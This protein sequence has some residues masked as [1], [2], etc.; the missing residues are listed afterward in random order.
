ME[1]NE[2]VIRSLKVFNLK[3]N[4]SISDMRAAYLGRTSHKKFQKIFFGDEQ[5]EKEFLKY[6]EAYMIY[7][8]NYDEDNVDLST[9]P[10]DKGFKFI[11]NQ[12]LYHMIRQQYMKAFEKF[13]EA[14]KLNSED[15][16]LLLYL[17][18]ILM[19]RKNY[20]AA[21]KYLLKAAE[22]DKNNDDSWF[23][24]G[25]IYLKTGNLNKAL[26]MFETC[27]ILNPLRS[28]VAAKLKEIK[29]GLGIESPVKAPKEKRSFLNK[30]LKIFDKTKP[31]DK[32]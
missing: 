10:S 11:F 1:T 7:L 29:T 28:E 26:R 3:E 9:Y 4:A 20:Y 31:P 30:I 6:Y 25:E 17:S 22:L 14:F 18:V 23:Y 21:E 5:I 16:T 8:K 32:V 27:K 19:K 12:G 15:G 13:Q 24:L 2:T